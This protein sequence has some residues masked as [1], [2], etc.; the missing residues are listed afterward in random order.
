[1]DVDDDD[2]GMKVCGGDDVSD[3]G[4]GVVSV[5]GCGE[6]EWGRGCVKCGGSVGV[7]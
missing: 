5:V 2:G 3:D 7:D 1:M 6:C 4:G